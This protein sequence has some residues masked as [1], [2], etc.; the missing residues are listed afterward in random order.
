MAD[1]VSLLNNAFP[2]ADGAARTDALLLL[3][4]LL[5]LGVSVTSIRRSLDAGPG[6]DRRGRCTVKDMNNE[7]TTELVIID[8][9]QQV[10]RLLN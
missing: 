8:P 6:T 7:A 1:R 9:T 2:T 3:L 10:E 4:L 5:L